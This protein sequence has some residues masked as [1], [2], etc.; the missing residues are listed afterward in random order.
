MATLT[1]LGD[2]FPDAPLS[3]R[4]AA[5]E[6]PVER[7]ELSQESPWR[8]HTMDLMSVLADSS[9]RQIRLAGFFQRFEYYASQRDQVHLRRHIDGRLVCLIAD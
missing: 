7:Y 1:G 2:H 5:S 4:G 6:K 8:G 3:T 9:P